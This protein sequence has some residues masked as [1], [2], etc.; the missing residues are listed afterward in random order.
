MAS[1]LAQIG[2]TVA[3]F[4]N[5]T[6]L[7]YVGSS[8][9]SVFG[10]GRSKN[11]MAGSMAQYGAVGTLFAIVSMEAVAVAKVDWH[12]YR[13]AVSGKDEDR[14]EVTTHPALS[15]LSKP[16]DFYSRQELFET[17]QQHVDL[18][19]MAFWVVARNP[20][21]ASMP[22]ELWPV[23]PDKMTPATDP[24]KFLVGWVYS[25]PDGEKVPLDVKD[26]L[27]V[28]MPDPENPYMGLGPVQSIKTDAEA[29]RHIAEWNRNF[30]RNSAEPGGIIQFDSMLDDT[31]FTTLQRRWAEQHRGIGNAHR[32]A[33]LEKG[34]WIERKYT[35]RDMEFSTLRQ[36]SSD[37]IREAFAF[38]ALMLGQVKDVNRA[39]ADASERFFAKYH[40]VTRLDRWK[41]LLNNDYL[42]LFG[43]L[44]VGYEW[45]YDSPVEADAEIDNASRDSKTKAAVAMVGAGWDA[46]EVL[47]A[48]GL[49]EIKW[50]KPAAPTPPP[51]A[52]PNADP[53]ADPGADPAEARLTRILGGVVAQLVKAT[54][55]G[56][57]HDDAGGGERRG[58]DVALNAAHPGSG[59]DL[60]AVQSDWQG[61][62][63]EL[64]GSW[65]DVTQAQR[66]EIRMQVEQAINAND[67]GALAHL[68]V[69]TTE[70]NQLLAIAM[71]AIAEDGAMSAIMEARKQGQTIGRG[72]ADEGIL[73]QVA[74]LTALLLAQGLTNA[75][76]REALR[77]YSITARGADVANAV[78]AHLA[79]LS[80]AFL[81]DNLGGALSRAQMAGRLATF[82]QAPEASLYSSEVLD[83]HIC[84]PCSQ[85]S[86]KFLG[87]STD[88]SMVDATYPNGQYVHCLGGIRCRGQVVAVWRTDT[89]PEGGDQ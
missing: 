19:G 60:S 56:H 30:F 16:N 31:E 45:D 34:T 5:E 22:L 29:T 55:G 81:R 48:M 80:D 13:K 64:L 17:G 79:G 88:Q 14:V 47:E 44:G 26:V 68:S 15:V 77:N 38:P 85:V 1:L 36:V 70:S 43:P 12:L 50:T 27:A 23:R 39:S 58:R 9:V 74:A 7:P 83:S 3:R 54:A 78:D 69:T 66:D 40:T 51:G 72:H 75:A 62:L 86:G 35:Q 76:A 2:Q 82:R 18:A 41:G 59:V 53:S 24:N 49:P 42:P 37:V 33:I 73:A 52:D 20:L 89:T 65:R 25:G 61:R 11:D 46:D 6:P 21:F 87:L 10:G 71:S 32:V 57:W 28:R 8:Q 4:R 84:G 63:D 67:V